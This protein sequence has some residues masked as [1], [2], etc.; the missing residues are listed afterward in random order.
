MSWSAINYNDLI[1][2]I[3]NTVPKTRDKLL[4]DSTNILIQLEA[5]HL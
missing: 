3:I 4:F 2:H 5:K 1:V